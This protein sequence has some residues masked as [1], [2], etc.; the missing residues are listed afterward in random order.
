MFAGVGLAIAGAFLLANPA[1]V[2]GNPMAA[3]FLCGVFVLVG[4]GI[5][6]AAIYG[7][8]KLKEQAAAQQSAPDSP[9]LWQKDWAASRADSKDLSNVTGPWLL[10]GVLT[11]ISLT[12]VALTAHAPSRNSG[13]ALPLALGFSVPLIV[14]AG[15]ALRATIRRKRFGKTYFDFAS[16]PFSPGKTLKGSIHLRF[17][18]NARHGIDLTLS[19]V[20]QV[21]TGAGKNRSVNRIVLWQSQ[22]NVPQQALT[23][24]PMGDATIPVN[25]VVP[26]DAYET[27]HDRSDK[28]TC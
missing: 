18:T 2:H 10:A 5:V 15:L 16:L 27:N 8:R 3:V 9:W 20:R 26:S 28:R 23:P 1:N 19:C 22:A 4:S 11:F 24:G 12:L 25:F 17:N 14:L 21:I 13:S 6:Y 7:N